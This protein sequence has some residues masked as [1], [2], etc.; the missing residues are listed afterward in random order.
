M[1]L[2]DLRRGAALAF[3]AC[4]LPVLALAADS[5]ALPA[6]ESFFRNPDVGN[7]ELSPSGRFLALTSRMKDRRVGLVVLDLQR[8]AAGKVVAHYSDI[9]IGRFAWVSDDQLVFD[10]V[11]LSRG[12]GEQARWRGLVGVTVDGAST[13]HLIQND[14]YI[15]E[16]LPGTQ[17]LDATHVVL[18]VPADGKDV[19]VG[20]WT[21]NARRELTHILPLRLDVTTTRTR[22]IGLGAPDHVKDWLFDP[23]GEPRVAIATN[24]GQTTFYWKGPQ[25]QEWKELARGPTY[26]MPFWPAFVD[27]PGALYVTT[28]DGAAG[29]SVLRRFDFAA[30]QPEPAPLVRAAGFDVRGD[31]VHDEAGRL[32]GVRVRTDAE[33]TAWLDP[34]LAQMQK[35]VDARLP[36]RI[37][38]LSCRRCAADD[39]VVLVRSWSDQDPGRFTLYDPQ[40]KQ[41][42]TLAAARPDIEPRRMATLDL[43]R[44]KT[45]DGKEMPVWVTLPPGAGKGTPRPAVVLVHGGPWIKGGSWHWDEDAQF[46]ASRGYVVI[47]PEFRGSRGYGQT[48][49]RAGWKQWGLAMQDDVADATKWAAA[50][51]YVDA[52]KVCIAGA[53]YGGYATLMGLARD[54]DLYRC[55]IAWVAVTDPRL[56]A[57]HAWANTSREFIEHGMPNLIGDVE[58][59]AAMLADAGNDPEWVFYGDEGHGW[60]KEAN[61]YDW[62]RRMETFLAKHLK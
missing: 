3:L 60:L 21:F 25:A 26:S 29:T 14:H 36:G 54:G 15:G 48:W 13:R 11:D 53:S 9:D 18:H 4:Q 39:A 43:H 35:D 22:T 49:F 58:K 7:V 23:K 8:K 41:F 19:I 42:Q 12:T 34:R 52:Q 57:D 17:P 6:V 24:E 40:S 20:R 44:I 38:R 51:G 33:T 31:P 32:I 16:M 46:L 2:S 27:V 45:R 61:R 56:L 59:D 1:N 30:G 50:Q 55:G 62:A 37:N 5:P 47:E 10:T 28:S